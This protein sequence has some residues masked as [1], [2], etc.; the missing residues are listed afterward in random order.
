MFNC[1]QLQLFAPVQCT[2][3]RCVTFT[4]RSNTMA[5]LYTRLHRH[6]EYHYYDEL[7]RMKM[8]SSS[9]DP[10]FCLVNRR[11]HPLSLSQEEKQNMICMFVHVRYIFYVCTRKHQ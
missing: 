7:K 2:Y 5:L 3:V 4:C 11:A 6:R 9:F 10:R 1:T 8:V